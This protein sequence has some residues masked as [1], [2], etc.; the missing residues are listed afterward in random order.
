MQ[1]KSLAV[2]GLT[3]ALAAAPVLAQEGFWTKENIGR[4]VGAATGALLG[5]RIGGGS[6]KLAAVAIGTLAGY[7]VGGAVGRRLSQ[8]D[9]AGIAHTTQSALN[10]G[11]TQTW[12]NPDSGVY[13]RVSVGEAQPYAGRGAGAGPKLGEA[14]PLELVNAYYTADANVNVRGGPG[15]EFAILHTLPRGSH[16]PVIGKVEGTDWYMIAEGGVG[17]GFLYGPIMSA[18]EGQPESQ[19]AIRE[20]MSREEAPQRYIAST[21]ECRQI[22][23]EVVLRNGQ[24]STHRFTACRQPDGSWAEV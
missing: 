17:S 5:S 13:T 8:N 11:R 7:W 10:T 2:V 19:N 24:K 20:A 14:P 3:A 18:S 4:A 1:G 9:R 22:T 23:Q 21:Q 12:R 6:G 15:T 16:V